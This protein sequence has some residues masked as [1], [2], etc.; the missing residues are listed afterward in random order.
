MEKILL[1]KGNDLI[2]LYSNRKI[3]C[4]DAKFQEVVLDTKNTRIFSKSQM[5]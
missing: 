1:P 3:S 5:K 2:G 4:C